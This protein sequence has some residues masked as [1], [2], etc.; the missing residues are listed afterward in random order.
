M[1]YSIITYNLNNEAN[2]VSHL[3]SLINI[4][5]NDYEIILVDDNSS[6]QSLTNVY[7]KLTIRNNIKIIKGNSNEGIFNCLNIGIK[8]SRGNFILFTNSNIILNIDILNTIDENI[9]DNKDKI[10]FIEYKISNY[11][12]YLYHNFII[13]KELVKHIGYFDTFDMYSDWD[14]KFRANKISSI[15]YINL[16]LGD[17]IKI[18]DNLN[19]NNNVYFKNKFSKFSNRLYIP[20]RNYIKYFDFELEPYIY[21]SKDIIITDTNNDINCLQHVKVKTT[22]EYEVYDLTNKKN[23]YIKINNKLQSLLG[24]LTSI[25][26]RKSIFLRKGIYAISYNIK[27]DKVIQINPISIS[28]KA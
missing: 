22:G 10:D 25:D 20:H 21:S 26:K 13:S 5:Y 27:D 16:I 23:I 14:Y 3:S 28:L 19:N 7:N 6:D 12:N 15:I 8:E 17:V 11:T 9:E 2:I 4:N 18:R 1:K 24:S